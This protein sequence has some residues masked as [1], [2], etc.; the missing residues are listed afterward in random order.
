MSLGA[1]L[2][3][4]GRM[5]RDRH[6]TRRE[7]L[8]ALVSVG[9]GVIA[10]GCAASGLRP[11]KPDEEMEH[12]SQGE[13]EV[14][15]AED[16]MRE[17]GV[18][19]RVLLVYREAMRR[20]ETRER[21]PR[22]AIAEGA[23]VIRTFIEDYHERLEEEFLFPRFRTAGVLVDLVGILEEQH[24][25]GRVLTER[26][27]RFSGKGGDRGGLAKALAAFVRMYEPHEA[28]EDTVL[29]PAI[30]QVVTP[31]EYDALGEEFEEREHR[32]FGVEGFEGIVNRVAELEK[33]LG[34]DDL[35]RVTPRI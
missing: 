24:R 3:R 8:A 30:R 29:F 2:Q 35:A 27:T 16:L 18:L 22:E 21:A 19:K 20:L 34:I 28:R 1:A 13:D 4:G 15:P 7:C 10:V 9:A 26:I 32:L 11:R 23:A 17:H 33:A 25:V 14:S 12:G 5:N 6:R 31:K